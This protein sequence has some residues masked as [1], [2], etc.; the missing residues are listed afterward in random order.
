MN[1]EMEFIDVPEV[2]GWKPDEGITKLVSIVLFLGF[3]V[4]VVLTFSL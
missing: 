3:L 2:E 1:D 4:I